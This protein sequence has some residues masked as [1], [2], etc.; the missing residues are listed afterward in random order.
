MR[1]TLRFSVALHIF[2]R[3]TFAIVLQKKVYVLF[4]VKRFLHGL[5]QTFA[6]LCEPQRIE[7]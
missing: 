6:V 4:A 7:A 5:R 1:F 2:C 3:R